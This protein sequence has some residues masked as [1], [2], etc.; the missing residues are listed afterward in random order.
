MTPFRSLLFGLICLCAGGNLPLSAAATWNEPPAEDEEQQQDP[1]AEDHPAVREARKLALAGRRNESINALQ[2]YLK[3][4]EDDQ[5]A[6]RL[7]KRLQIEERK[8]ELAA[9]ATDR[10]AKAGYIL[11]DPAYAKAKTQSPTH[12]SQQL[13]IVEHL[14]DKK[15]HADAAEACEQILIHYPENEAVLIL[16]ER[17]LAY[18]VQK[19]QEHILREQDIAGKRAMNDVIRANTFPPEQRPIPRTVVIYPEDL[20]EAERQRVQAQLKIRLTQMKAEQQPLIDIL[21]QVFAYA[22]LNFII[23]DSA[24]V[25][26]TVTLDLIDESVEHI[27][28]I[29][30]RMVPLQFNYQG[31][32][33]YVTSNENPI[34]RTEVIRLR[35]GLSN[36][37]AEAD[38]GDLGGG[39]GGG[40]GNGGSG[41]GGGGG[42][43]LPTGGG[44]GGGGGEDSGLTDIERFLE[45]A[46]SE[47]GLI[48]WPEGS[49]YYLD[50]K[51]NTLVVRSSPYVIS[52]IK[53]VLEFID[54]P[55]TQVLIEAKFAEV[56]TNALNEVGV[57][58]NVTGYK[59][60]G[61][62]GNVILGGIGRGS[63]P[64]AP[65]AIAAAPEAFGGAITSPR[66]GLVSGLIGGGPDLFPN[67]GIQLNL[68]E[69]RGEA[70]V[71]SE[72][73]ILTLNNA[74]GIIDIRRDFAYV[75]DFTSRSNRG[76][77]GGL[78]DNL[79][80]IDDI[81]DDNDFNLG[82][83]GNA[84]LVPEFE[85][86]EEGIQLKVKPSISLNS[87]LVT[88]SV[89]PVVRSLVSFQE[90]GSQSLDENATVLGTSPIRQPEFSTR[91]L[92]TSLNVKNG[93]TVV[94]GGLLSE[95]TENDRNG[96]PGIS[97]VPGLGRLFRS[98]T[99]NMRRSKLLV[100]LTVHIIDPS[101]AEVSEEIRHL[102]D[103][104][105][106]SLPSDVKEEAYAR[107]RAEAEAA[108]KA[109]AER[110]QEAER[111]SEGA[112]E[113]SPTKKPGGRRP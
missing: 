54:R 97:D 36:V 4:Y 43:D 24:L 3:A 62:D 88:L 71:L 111:M 1:F 59:S 99:R 104:V 101:G 63:L 93:Q 25:E 22:G 58:W 2:I 9:I 60:Q 46:L 11:P 39:G 34:M 105:R 33:V 84:V 30:Q 5:E 75:A 96:V 67:F 79:D 6:R 64:A 98:D 28:E 89:A 40:G 70:N 19:E 87:D 103:T 49:K 53:R 10:T 102:N 113:H 83:L 13:D 69:Q 92:F 74:T 51:M 23:L 47:E 29:V 77:V 38:I 32:S 86:E 107:E 78:L 44:G 21:R 55:T 106:I 15:R 76:N 72:P 95:N 18:L 35:Y 112:F 50:Y 14:I 26:E 68:L 108:E 91:R 110:Q 52:E 45:Q 80:D 31:G 8:S 81:D 109:A 41:S 61:S 57:D 94:L 65:F 37:L 7:L 82:D 42:F 73:K 17:T 56:S 20:A 16:L 85:V 66:G 100:F 90:A 48:D 12:I 27:L